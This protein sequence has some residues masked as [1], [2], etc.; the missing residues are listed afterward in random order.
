MT[1][2]SQPSDP[3]ASRAAGKPSEGRARL[4]LYNTL[5]HRKEDF[6]PIDPQ[7][8][9]ALRLRPDRLRFRPYR[10][11]PAD[12][13]L[14]RAVPP[15]APSLRRRST[16]SM[17]ATS[18]TST[19]RS[20]RA[21]Q[22]DYPGL[23]LN[24]AIA[25]V[26]EAT[27]RQFHDDVAA[28]GALAPTEEPRATQYIGKMRDDDRAARRPGRRLCRRGSRAVL[29]LCDG[30]AA[31]RAAL[32]GARATARSTRCW[33]ARGSTSRLTSA[34]RWISC[35]GSRRSP[36]SRAGRARPESPRRGARLAYRMLGDVD[37]DAARAVRR[38]PRMRRPEPQYFDIHGGGIDLVFPHHENEI[39]QS[40]CAFGSKRMANVWIH[41]GFLQVESEK[42]SKSLGNFVTIDELLAHDEVR[43]PKMVRRG[44]AACDAAQPTT[45]SRSTGR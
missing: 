16:S 35:C 13:R 21:P 23:P 6:A 20:M 9:Q 18:P 34:T 26:T 31:L 36:T 37:G 22:H 40:C 32:R 4:R 43:R 14:R 12:H 17:S 39:A 30:R 41:N 19:T 44:V 5:T 8:G 38:R 15:A 42:M 25:Q 7:C 3:S 33:P 10:Q 28:L 11:R 27:E 45:A 29:A 1:P 24:E 2:T